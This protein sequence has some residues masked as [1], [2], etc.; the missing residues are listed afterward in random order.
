MHTAFVPYVEVFAALV[1]VLSYVD[2]CRRVD[3]VPY[4]EVCGA[5]VQVVV[6][7]SGARARLFRVLLRSI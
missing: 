4:V 3:H 2:V 6:Q 7:V 1:Q 5:L